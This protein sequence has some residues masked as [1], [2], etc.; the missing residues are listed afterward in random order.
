MQLV[1]EN[2]PIKDLV[3]Y[4]IILLIVYVILGTL[5]KHVTSVPQHLNYT[6]TC[7][8]PYL[9]VIMVKI[10]VLILEYVFSA[11]LMK[12]FNA[13]VN[14]FILQIIAQLAKIQII[15]IIY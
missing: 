7:A 12:N 6:M 13:F 14:Q 2:A 10:Y 11:L 15:V 8:I 9:P 3:N 5:V 4:R 1:M